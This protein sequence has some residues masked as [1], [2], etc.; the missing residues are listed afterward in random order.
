MCTSIERG[1]RGL[2]AVLS[3]TERRGGPNVDH[4]RSPGA[5]QP[6][7][8]CNVDL[9]ATSATSRTSR[10][11]F[12]FAGSV[13]LAPPR[14]WSRPPS[15]TGS[16]GRVRSF[17]SSRRPAT[18][19]SRQHDRRQPRQW[20]VCVTD[21][22]CKSGDLPVDGVL[23]RQA[24]DHRSRTSSSGL[25][26]ARKNHVRVEP[27]PPTSASVH[28]ATSTR[29]R[30]PE[31]ALRHHWPAIALSSQ[32][33]VIFVGA[34]PAARYVPP[35]TGTNPDVRIVA[36]DSVG[37][38]TSAVPA[39]RRMILPVWQRRAP[40]AR[41]VLRRRR[42]PGRGGRHVRPVNWPRTG[43]LVLAFHRHRRQR[44]DLAGRARHARHG[45]WYRATLISG[46]SAMD[47]I[48]QQYRVEDLRRRRPRRRAGPGRS[49]ICPGAG[50][51]GPAGEQ[52]LAGPT[53]T[54]AASRTARV[55]AGC[56]A[57]C[58]HRASSCSA[59]RHTSSGLASSGS[60]S[61]ARA[62]PVPAEQPPGRPRRSP[63]VLP[64]RPRTSQ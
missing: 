47:T 14:R 52:P 61:R 31:G 54:G 44:R 63:G 59:A 13:K 36:V 12:N 8:T 18:L 35:G 26:G 49:V 60:P 48:Y 45:S 38:V 1:R 6:R 4:H 24:R 40:A 16:C 55:A 17:R 42:R 62:G 57:R 41:R 5:V 39:T 21:S 43:F 9:R 50:A 20:F 23:R 11:G 37:S 28:W 32:V 7:T 46:A 10:E 34:A 64:R 19:A 29:T 56:A 30:T 58:R 27:V 51:P 33:D 25:L 2:T 15:G 3:R 53:S 22:R